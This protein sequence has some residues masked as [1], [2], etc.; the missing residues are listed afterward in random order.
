MSKLRCVAPA[1]VSPQGSGHGGSHTTTA[2]LRTLRF[3]RFSSW[4]SMLHRVP[5]PALTTGAPKEFTCGALCLPRRCVA[6][7]VTPSATELRPEQRSPSEIAFEEALYTGCAHPSVAGTAD[8]VNVAASSCTPESSSPPIVV[9]PHIEELAPA[10]S[11]A[12]VEAPRDV[13][14]TGGTDPDALLVEL[15]GKNVPLSPSLQDHPCRGSA[16]GGSSQLPSLPDSEKERCMHL[17]AEQAFEEAL[18]GDLVTGGDGGGDA[19]GNCS[20]K[21]YGFTSDMPTA[22]FFGDAMGGRKD[23]R[24]GSVSAAITA[25]SQVVSSRPY[26]PPKDHLPPLDKEKTSKDASTPP[27]SPRDGAEASEERPAE[28]AATPHVSFVSAEAA[29]ERA[30][31]DGVAVEQ[32]AGEVNVIGSSDACVRKADGDETASPCASP[33]LPAPSASPDT[34]APAPSYPDDDVVGAVVCTVND[35]A[36]HVAMQDTLAADLDRTEA[37]ST[38]QACDNDLKLDDSTA[39][40]KA[41]DTTEGSDT[42]RV[43]V[44]GGT[45]PPTVSMH[46]DFN[47]DHRDAPVDHFALFDV[48]FGVTDHST[49]AVTHIDPRYRVK[50][51]MPLLDRVSK[52]E[53]FFSSGWISHLEEA[54]GVDAAVLPAEG[55][56]GSSMPRP[57]THRE[58]VG[59]TKLLR[60]L[61]FRMLR[62]PHLW[63]DQV[64]EVVLLAVEK[65]ATFQTGCAGAVRAT[66]GSEDALFSPPGEVGE[67]G[68]D[69]GVVS[70]SDA[71]AL[72]CVTRHTCAACVGAAMTRIFGTDP[73]ETHFF[74][75]AL[76]EALIALGDNGS[77]S[78]IGSNEF[79]SGFEGPL[80]AWNAFVLTQRN[81]ATGVCG[82]HRPPFS[83]GEGQP[84]INVSDLA[85]LQYCEAAASWT[86]A[87]HAGSPSRPAAAAADAD[88]G[89]VPTFDNGD[90]LS[91]GQAGKPLPRYT[92]S[93]D[94]AATDAIPMAW[95]AMSEEE[96]NTFLFGAESAQLSQRVRESGGVYAVYGQNNVSFEVESIFKEAEAAALRRKVQ[97]NGETDS[98]AVD[99]GNSC[100]PADTSFTE[101]LRAQEARRVS[102]YDV[103]RLVLGWTNVE[104][105]AV[106]AL[107]GDRFAFQPS[108]AAEFTARSG[109]TSRPRGGKEDKGSRKGSPK[110]PFL[111]QLVNKEDVQLAALWERFTLASTG[112]LI[113]NLLYVRRH[114][115]S[116]VHDAVVDVAVQKA[117]W[118]LFFARD[119]MRAVTHPRRTYETLWDLHHALVSLFVLPRRVGWLPFSGSDRVGSDS[120]NAKAARI[121]FE[122]L[123]LHSQVS[124]ACFGCTHVPL[125]RC[126]STRS[127][128]SSPVGQETAGLGEKPNV[129]LHDSK[130][131]VTPADLYAALAGCYSV[132]GAEVRGEETTFLAPGKEPPVL[133]CESAKFETLSALQKFSVAFCFPLRRTEKDGAA[134]YLPVG[135][136]ATDTVAQTD[137]ARGTLDAEEDPRDW[138]GAPSSSAESH[139]MWGE[140]LSRDCSRARRTVRVGQQ[141]TGSTKVE[142]RDNYATGDSLMLRVQSALEDCVYNCL[143]SLRAAGALEAPLHSFGCR[144]GDSGLASTN[145]SDVQ[146]RKVQRA[147]Q[148]I[149]IAMTE[150]DSVS[151]PIGSSLSLRGARVSPNAEG[152]EAHMPASPR[153]R[154]R[155]P[156]STASSPPSSPS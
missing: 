79:L 3:R 16:I 20:R 70:A 152:A 1:A 103:D 90:A 113:S 154:G 106:S 22:R 125:L 93:G 117:F 85:P 142:A 156:K 12:T 48:L 83:F 145:F 65:A 143:H 111:W 76:C 54:E 80:G 150:G 139:S 119:E 55:L 135:V 110:M 128:R 6:S 100:A 19:L 56:V 78:G 26:P 108:L 102:G 105:A 60:S 121:P 66:A 30:L 133:N 47:L 116:L 35:V 124:Y 13:R 96:Q 120:E 88:R 31:Y 51:C 18:Y 95:G 92:P 17:T 81:S 14:G 41:P 25:T 59:R 136:G 69:W 148:E 109:T 101:V 138:Q 146:R 86:D 104:R 147:V 58:V 64:Q 123:S 107:P 21:S 71:T 82:P 137:P 94:S 73:Q 74:S 49:G 7:Q 84:T 75:D 11:A 87:R 8:V 33:V 67:D 24:E 28:P 23:G 53:L 141:M 130:P 151:S 40:P 155:K 37:Q 29:F 72:S 77:A 2:L 134:L 42:D 91:V 34:P 52:R 44:D 43:A 27:Q 5:S 131:Y 39:C 45:P 126:E 118:L 68:A 46:C 36:P 129:H 4:W 122:A 144:G 149:A 38:Q 127:P 112:D 57:F 99:G 114:A 50:R 153:R 61:V 132:Q 140:E 98:D 9:A 63:W 89:R 10:S 62:V 15:V 115:S 32:L 97:E